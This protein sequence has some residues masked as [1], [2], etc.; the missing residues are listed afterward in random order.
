MQQGRVKNDSLRYAAQRAFENIALV[1]Y[2]AA[3][4]ALGF[5]SNSVKATCN[6]CNMCSSF[7]LI[8]FRRQRTSHCG[9]FNDMSIVTGVKA[10]HNSSEST[11]IF[12]GYAQICA[13]AIFG[14]RT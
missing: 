14:A 11:G 6:F 9:L 5:F 7:S 3:P 12:K 4:T 8:A 2:F 13:R 1:T 10:E